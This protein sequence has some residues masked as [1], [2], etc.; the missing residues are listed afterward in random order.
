MA[1]PNRSQPR[2]RALVVSLWHQ[3][4]PVTRPYQNY[5]VP[6]RPDNGLLITD[7]EFCKT[8]GELLIADAQQNMDI[9]DKR[10]VPQSFDAYAIAD[11]IVASEELFKFGVFVPDED[12]PT[13]KALQ[14]AQ[15][16]LIK[17]AKLLVQEGDIKYSKPQT[18]AEISDLN[19]WA[20]VQMQ[21]ERE[22]VYQGIDQVKEVLPHCPNCGME[23]KILDPASC[24]NCSLILDVEK[25]RK[26]GLPI[27]NSVEVALAGAGKPGS[28][29]PSARG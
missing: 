10:G 1:R 3:P 25:A 17:R 9:G 28:K 23:Q 18:R 14:A 20:V 21:E 5:T 24:W 11:D 26:L 13:L 12:Q 15:G 22:W 19:R 29:Q 6:A 8:Y 4:F 7:R 27:P 2:P 16:L